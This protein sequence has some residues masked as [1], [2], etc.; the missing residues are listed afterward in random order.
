MALN[1]L[2][3]Q[4]HV[5]LRGLGAS[6]F[7]ED[8]PKRPE[9]M[10]PVLYTA[11]RI[12]LERQG[13]VSERLGSSRAGDLAEALTALAD[14]VVTVKNLPLGGLRVFPTGRF[15]VGGINVYDEIVDS[16]REKSNAE[17]SSPAAGLMQEVG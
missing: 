1:V 17:A 4:I 13:S 2:V 15:Y 5:E 11:Q 16:W 9:G 8:T 6:V 10:R 7:C 12:L 3:R 14:R